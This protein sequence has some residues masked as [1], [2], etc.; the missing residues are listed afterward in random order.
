[1][2]LYLNSRSLLY[3]NSQNSKCNFVRNDDISPLIANEQDIIKLSWSKIMQ[4]EV[5]QVFDHKFALDFQGKC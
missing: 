5:V 4:F 2:I 3:R 1:M